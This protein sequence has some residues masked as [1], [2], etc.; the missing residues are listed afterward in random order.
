[1]TTFLF[2]GGPKHGEPGRGT[3][4]ETYPIRSHGNSG[5]VVDRYIRTDVE[6]DLGDPTGPTRVY[7]IEA[8]A[9]NRIGVEGM[10][11]AHVARH[12]DRLRE[13]FRFMRTGLGR[14]W[15]A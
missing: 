12:H 8:M 5:T 10:T 13:H 3:M 9:D 4:T 2:I 14:P 11:V 1:M 6:V 15:G 7:A